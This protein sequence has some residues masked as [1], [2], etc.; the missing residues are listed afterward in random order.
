MAE[1]IRSL[2]CDGKNIRELHMP[3]TINPAQVSQTL[4]VKER[5]RSE[6]AKEPTAADGM[7]LDGPQSEILAYFSDALKEIR[8]GYIEKLNR[9]RTERG[10]LSNKIDI[11][12]AKDQ[13]QQIGD[14]VEANLMQLQVENEGNLK[15]A[16]LM[17]A[18]SL[19]HLNVFKHKH[20][21]VTTE[22]HYP[23]SMWSHLSWVAVAALFEWILL[24]YFY[25]D[26]GTG[27]WA[28]GFFYASLFSV[29]NL[30]VAII[31]GNVLRQINHQSHIRK[32]LGVTGALICVIAFLFATILVAHFRYAAQEFSQQQQEA[33][34]AAA[35]GLTTGNTT[36][37][38]Q[39][40]TALSWNSAKAIGN[41]AWERARRDWN[42]L[43]DPLGWI[44][45]FATCLFG[46]V[47]AWKGYGMDDRYPGYGELD[48]DFLKKDHEYEEA[49]KGY[50]ALINGLFDTKLLD[51]DKIFRDTEANVQRFNRI[52]DSARMEVQKFEGEKVIVRDNCNAVVKI[53]RDTYIY[54]RGAPI[55]SYFEAD[56]K[57]DEAIARDLHDIADLN[58]ADELKTHYSVA[59][60]EFSTLAAENRKD[61]NTK[62][63][64]ALRGF[65]SY[66]S[67]LQEDITKSLTTDFKT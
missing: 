41:M 57:L 45:I 5:A 9:F 14:D 25:K 34:A 65:Q 4:N 12:R 61:M 35:A 19:R 20:D 28:E 47:T 22:A 29:V 48:R 44:V 16:F 24:S 33:Q 55:P 59:L 17:K 39:A 46:V 51:Q 58:E 21:L 32:M 42:D 2:D 56:I 7:T 1:Y 18:K 49:K 63:T 60:R 38:S 62:K 31:L 43:P 8:D 66:V 23:D 52:C 53:Y 15:R 6:A 50:V 37:L 10:E 11:S 54:V 67:S 13:F 36:Q 26:I 3:R 27:G 30:L 40:A 64:S